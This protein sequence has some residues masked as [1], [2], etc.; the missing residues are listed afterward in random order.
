[1]LSWAQRYGAGGIVVWPLVDFRLTQ[2]FGPTD[3]TLQPPLCWHGTCY[4]HFHDGLDLAVALGT[5]IHAIASGRVIFA[6]RF[7]DGNMVVEI[8][9]TPSVVSIYA[10]LQ[11]DPFVV[12]GDSVNAGESVG[13][14]GMT[15]LTTGPHLHLGV[16]VDGQPFDPMLILPPRP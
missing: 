15:G 8:E 12:E 6:G 2:R 11:P 9:H 4:A 13:V 10:H 16:H 3:F 7:S 1:V 14:V 5:Q